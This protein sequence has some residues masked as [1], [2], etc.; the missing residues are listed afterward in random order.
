MSV[1]LT[2]EPDQNKLP[3]DSLREFKN[4]I[5]SCVEANFCVDLNDF[6]NGK[7]P[8]YYWNAAMVLADDEQIIIEQFEYEGVV[9]YVLFPAKTKK[10]SSKKFRVPNA[11]ASHNER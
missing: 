3:N 9:R 6:M 2:I 10:L 8:L 4:H 11:P 1:Q 5:L 7:D